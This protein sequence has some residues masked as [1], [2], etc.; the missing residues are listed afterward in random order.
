[1]ADFSG[2]PDAKG[3]LSMQELRQAAILASAG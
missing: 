2:Q 1:V 3:G